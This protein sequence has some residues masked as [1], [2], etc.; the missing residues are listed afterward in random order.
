[1][2]TGNQFQLEVRF[3]LMPL[4]KPDMDAWLEEVLGTPMTYAPL[5]VFP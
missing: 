1:M 2:T 3:N 5:P 4:P